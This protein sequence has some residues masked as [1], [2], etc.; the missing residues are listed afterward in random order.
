MRDGASGRSRGFGFLTFKDVKTVN[1]VMVKEHWLDG[2]I[3]SILLVPECLENSRHLN[4]RLLCS[5]CV[6]VILLL[7]DTVHQLLTFADYLSAHL[8]PL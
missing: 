2:K 4:A 3:V 7:L 8:D 6:V 1:I 5:A